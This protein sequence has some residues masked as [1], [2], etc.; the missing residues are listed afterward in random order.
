MV[1]ISFD[2]R[3]SHLMVKLYYFKAVYLTRKSITIWYDKLIYNKLHGK[4]MKYIFFGG[5][6][7]ILST[8]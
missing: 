1:K 8:G 4:R 5:Y 7:F 3:N 6:I 2:Q